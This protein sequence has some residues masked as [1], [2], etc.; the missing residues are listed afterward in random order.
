[1]YKIYSAK[2]YKVTFLKAAGAFKKDD[3]TKVGMAIAI[4][5]LNKGW[6]KAERELYADAKAAGCDKLIKKTA[7]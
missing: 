7:E 1:M 3:T 4:K 5:F 2:R 6:V